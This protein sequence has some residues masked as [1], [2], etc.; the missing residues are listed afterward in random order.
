VPEDDSITMN[1]L[2]MLPMLVVKK[3]MNIIKQPGKNDNVQ[4]RSFGIS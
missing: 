4:Q 2:L 3:R 1:P